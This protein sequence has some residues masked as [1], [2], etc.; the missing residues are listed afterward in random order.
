MYEVVLVI[1]FHNLHFTDLILAI[2]TLRPGSSVVVITRTD[3]PVEESGLDDNDTFDP[4]T[5]S[6]VSSS[7]QGTET[8]SVLDEIL[9]ATTFEKRLQGLER[10]ID[11]LYRLSLII[12]QPSRSSQNE[13]AERF[14]MTDDEGNDIDKSFADF[15]CH[16]VAH[17]FPDAPHFLRNKLSHG[18]VI[19]RKRFLYRQSHQ[20]KLS[21]ASSMR[22]ETRQIK[23]KADRD[24]EVESTVRGFN[25]ADG[26][27][28]RGASTP[29]HPIQTA[30]APSQTS[31]SAIA[32]QPLPLQTALEDVQS[33]HSTLF[34]AIHSV[35]APV[36]IPAAPKP[37]AGSKEFECPYCCLVLPI[38]QSKALRWRY[39]KF[40]FSLYGP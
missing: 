39:V 36:E 10:A 25:L 26:L 29:E 7:F 18:I 32:K 20:R 19:R 3:S 27:P 16:L 2:E 37:A 17:R 30:P 33:D 40:F 35:N 13:K 4:S 9:P 21:G 22:E 11:R 6:A 38:K 15:A 24:D 1:S 5:S 14:I 31:A 12:R 28:S 34:T 23:P 8:E